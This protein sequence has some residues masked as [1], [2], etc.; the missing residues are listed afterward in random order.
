M[1]KLRAAIIDDGA[2]DL[3]YD[4]VNCIS[5]YDGLQ[6]YEG[7]IFSN[8]RSHAST[9]MQII[10]KYTNISDIDWYNI[11][12]F[13]SEEYG[14]I[15]SF[16]K[17]LDFCREKGIKLIHL[18]L[19]T[20][21]FSYFERIKY[22]IELLLN[23][24]VII[25]AALSNEEEYTVPACLDG[26]IGVRFSTDLKDDRYIYLKNDLKGINFLACG[27]HNLCMDGIAELCKL[28]N[29]FAA[30]VITAKV[31]DALR[32]N[33]SLDSYGI[34]ER[35]KKTSEQ[36]LE[37]TL[38]MNSDGS[39][40]DQLNVPVVLIKSSDIEK[41]KKLVEKIN[42]LFIKEGYNS[43][44][45]H[46]DEAKINGLPSQG[47]LNFLLF[48]ENFYNCDIIILGFKKSEVFFNFHSYDVIVSDT[49]ENNTDN[50]NKGTKL[51][52]IDDVDSC[53]I[54]REIIRSFE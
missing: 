33:V 25:V 24:D 42:S 40:E 2:A 37:C 9:C 4:T 12:I 41:Q 7:E 48:A 8:N 11:N 22:E 20:R 26:V 13:S 32:E 53:D 47:L 51:I 49:D 17:A 18:S 34:M 30:P 43:I 36:C 28:S 50:L 3:I 46:G 14:K 27:S 10:K 15:S 52:K 45:F 38:R 5:I 23:N 39:S 31:I 29:S 35:L 54:F 44:Y 16:L 6:I 19:G 1:D 21:N